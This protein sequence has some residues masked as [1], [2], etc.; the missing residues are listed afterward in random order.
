[1]DSP[2]EKP[3]AGMKA[4][5]CI[6]KAMLL[7]ASS[8]LPNLP[9]KKMKNVKANTS[10]VNCS[11]AGIPFFRIRKNNSRLNDRREKI[12]KKRSLL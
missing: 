5:D 1:V 12:P 6:E 7:M 4:I 3:I 2:I 8:T 9:I 10:I 11:A